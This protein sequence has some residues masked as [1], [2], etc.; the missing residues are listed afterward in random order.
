MKT[1]L[2]A[3]TLGYLVL[4]MFAH[5]RSTPREDNHCCDDNHSL[6]GLRRAEVE[7]EIA[8]VAMKK[9]KSAGN[10]RPKNK[11]IVA[12]QRECNGQKHNGTG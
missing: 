9:G 8:P 3:A 6:Y 12:H 5:I 11:C 4:P 10:P 2:I 1:T 7:N